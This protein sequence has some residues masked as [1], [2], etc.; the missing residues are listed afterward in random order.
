[1]VSLQSINT[2]HS[3]WPAP[4]RYALAV[5]LFAIAVLIR[6][7]G[8][9][10]ESRLTFVTFYPTLVISFYLCG[11]GPGLWSILL[12]ILAGYVAFTPPLMA[13]QHKPLGD[14]AVAAFLPSAILIGLVIRQ[15][16]SYSKGM[17]S[18]LAE[19]VQVEQALRDERDK[20]Q[21]LLRNASDGIH[22]LDEDGNVVE[23]SN[24]FCQM[25]GY[26]REEVI[27]MNV[28][29]WDA[30]HTD[31]ERIAIVKRQFEQPV[32]HQFE[33][34]HRR[35]DGTVLDVEV[36]GYRVELA[37]RRLLFN[38][39]RDISAHKL[40]EQELRNSNQRFRTLF[41]S[42]PDATWIME[43]R[44]F[45]EC[46]QA[47]VELFGYRDRSAFLN[48]HP[49][50][51]SPPCQ[52]DG[53][54]SQAKAE[55]MMAIAEATGLHR[56]EWMHH[57]TDGSDFF[58][59]VTLSVIALEGQGS[60]HAV[61][62][63]ITE[64]KQAEAALKTSEERLRLA[65]SAAEIG[66]WDWDIER[67]QA[68]YDDAHYRLMGLPSGNPYDFNDF[69]SR[70][71]PN[72]RALLE[73]EVQKALTDE[74]YRY[75]VEYR[76]I[77]D[78]AGPRRWMRNKGQFYFK[79]GRCVR[80]LGISMD[81]TPQKALLEES[82]RNEQR[83]KDLALSMADW[84]WELDA[85]GRFTYAS[86]KVLDVLGY[87][88][89]ELLGKSAFDLMPPEEVERVGQVYWPIV[90]SKSAF[91]GMENL[92]LHKDGSRRYMLT[93]GVPI[94]GEDG[95]L[96]GYRGTDKDVTLQKAMALEIENERKRLATI[97]KTASDGIHLLDRDGLLID[98]NDAFLNML[99]YDRSAIGHLHVS[100]WES[101][102]DR[103]AMRLRLE[104][105][106][107][108]EDTLVFETRHRGRDGGILDIE[109]SCN[110]MSIEGERLL[111]A[112]SRDISARKRAEAALRDAELQLRTV[113]NTMEVGILV[114]DRQSARHI[115]VNDHFCRMFGYSREQVMAMTVA[116][117]APPDQRDFIMAS[118]A[119]A[120]NGNLGIK[121][122]RPF[123]RG[124]GTVRMMEI[125]DT[126]IELEGRPCLLGVFTDTTQRIEA[127]RALTASEAR[128][129]RLFNAAPI[130]M[131]FNAEGVA[132]AVNE[133][134]TE[135]YGYTVEDISDLSEWWRLAYPQPEYR[136]WVMENWE[137][138]L[139]KAMV[140]GTRIKPD[141]YRVTCKDGT[142]KT[143]LI[144]AA[145]IGD[146]LLVSLVDITERQRAEHELA[147]YRQHLEDLV[148]R[149]TAELG[150]ALEQAE[151][152]NRS[153][154]SFLASMSHE[155]RT[156]I[157]AMLGLT[158]IMRRQTEDSRQLESLDKITLAGQHLLS[159]INDILDLSKIE[160]GKFTLEEKPLLIE[161]MVGNVLSMLKE[162]ADE[163]GLGLIGE[164]QPSSGN[165]VGDP[166]RLRQ[167][168]LNYGA[169][170]IKFTPAGRIT[171]R[172]RLLHEDTEGG[173][174]RFEVQDTGIGIAPEAM[175][176]LFGAFEQADSSTTRKYGGT[177]LGLAITQR[178][179]AAMGGDSGAESTQ[180][181]GSIFWFTAR[182]RKGVAMEQPEEHPMS[183]SAE[184][185]LKRDYAGTR[186]LVAEDEPINREI[187]SIMLE[188]LGFV[189]DLAEDGIQAIELAGRKNYRLILMDMQMPEMDGLQ[190]TRVIRS[191]PGRETWPIIAMTANAF[192][193][194]RR[195][196]LA[197]G[198]SDF[199]S[200][201]VDPE[202]LYATLLKWLSGHRESAVIAPTHQSPPD[203]PNEAPVEELATFIPIPWDARYETGIEE[204]DLQ[205]RYFL[206]LIN[207]LAD[208]LLSIQDPRQR[209]P[210]IGELHRYAS[211][212]FAS[213]EN[214]MTKFGY[215]D[216]AAHRLHHRQWLD[217]LFGDS[218]RPASELIALLVEWFSTHT[219]EED[220]RIGEFVRDQ[221]R[222]PATPPGS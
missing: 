125:R 11:T 103:E 128:F 148:A 156:P 201:P 152:A 16:Q 202:L 217:K 4:A 9:P 220:R 13:I 27:G 190:A 72:D 66:I 210:L 203:T 38:A 84:I 44:R 153:K 164:V 145:P 139:R 198:M 68:D 88:P 208:K 57:R 162:R 204:I 41:E 94:L 95:T 158:H 174:W 185:V 138:S 8:L 108:S 180:G 165:F 205:H 10:M 49:D 170:A 69:L 150:V 219:V 51:V 50:E 43:H 91:S 144:S 55:R 99:G 142:V 176:K 26:T 160:A 42:S 136:Q 137:A 96:L 2:I 159:I 90:A 23:A 62:R 169:N 189:V 140:E 36:S 213:E 98:A 154:S 82:R 107:K 195:A 194:D 113:L 17:A 200:K 56:F 172:A 89:A 127:E 120:A 78:G 193:E 59:E 110:W 183:G 20:S 109:V 186:L 131:T 116:D 221:D 6:Y 15:L 123:M 53:E 64:R 71:D 134:F 168:L 106:R 178:I 111:Y 135:T 147:L 188:D 29:Q 1:M 22:I 52:P 196:C 143:A 39:S 112:A 67:D 197:A 7:W 73:N 79:D 115:F 31:A 54:D 114:A 63:D 199:I 129:R 74:H 87:T 3:R 161:A 215:P 122:N 121:E 207:R 28:A 48:V 214:L 179:A 181:V 34:R 37:G 175:S 155:I 130:P 97:L 46:N 126:D 86:E 19:R 60:I 117:L 61:V 157:G 40:A 146:N 104:D 70:V 222:L 119:S 33:T 58:A 100:D 77:G 184:T 124:D 166:T 216:L 182:L 25:L 105:T 149:K 85:E 206:K 5:A 187:A 211:F 30:F 18:A 209:E 45:V 212:H 102:F 83:F 167:A 163:K 21:A 24:S 192:D 12:S 133:S 35:K 47:A 92:N 171:I 76:L 177:G 132:S 118:F 218:S 65:Q 81:I 75:E 93:S 101:Q 14:V 141:E 151:A 173:L 32:R 80:A 191:L